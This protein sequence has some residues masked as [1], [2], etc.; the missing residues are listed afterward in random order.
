L[1]APVS[2]RPIRRYL[3]ETSYSHPPL[4]AITSITGI[5]TDEKHDG[6]LQFEFDIE[7]DQLNQATAQIIE[8]KPLENLSPGEIELTKRQISQL[9]VL[10]NI[11]FPDDLEYFIG[12]CASR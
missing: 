1:P 11:A 3:T 8:S 6:S 9:T 10:L 4:R 5:F 2:S 12:A 7:G